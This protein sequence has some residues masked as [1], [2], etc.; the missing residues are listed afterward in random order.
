MAQKCSIFVDYVTL[1]MIHLAPMIYNTNSMECY[2]KCTFLLFRT[3]AISDNYLKMTYL[4]S[5]Y[6]GK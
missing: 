5:N 6:T 1:L 2:I 3:L 4:C